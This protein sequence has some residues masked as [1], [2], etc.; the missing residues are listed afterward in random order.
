V[1]GHLHLQVVWTGLDWTGLGVS[2][3]QRG[4]C[5][6]EAFDSV[7][8]DHAKLQRQVPFGLGLQTDTDASM[9]CFWQAGR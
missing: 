7:V 3:V 2:K 1:K 4:L 9:S 8:K 6:D 5:F